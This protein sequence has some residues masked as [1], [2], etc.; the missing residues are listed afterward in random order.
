MC[1]FIGCKA[2]GYGSNRFIGRRGEDC[3]SIVRAN[4]YVFSHN[5]LSLTGTFNPQPFVD[6]RLFCLYNGELYNWQSLAEEIGVQVG[7]DGEILIPLYRKYGEKFLQKLDGE[8]AVVL[9]DLENQVAIFSSDSFRTKPIY[10]NADG[11][12]SYPSGLAKPSV[13]VPPNTTIVRDLKTGVEKSLLVH[14]FD[15]E[16][17]HK[18]TYD[19]W[20]AAF[21]AAILKRAKGKR[22]FLGLSSG[23]D[24]GAIHCALRKY[25]L[26]F[27]PFAIVGAE[28]VKMIQA[29]GV[30]PMVFTQA[31]FDWGRKFLNENMEDFEYQIYQTR[32]RIRNEESAFAMACIM[33]EARKHGARIYM[34]GQGADEIIADYGKWPTQSDFC[35]KFPEKLKPWRNFYGHCQEAYLAKEEHVGGTF[36]VE[37]RYAFLDLSVVQEF[38]WLHVDWKNRYYKA[39]IHEYMMRN[40]YPFRDGE[41]I[42]FSPQV[43]FSRVSVP[44]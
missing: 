33:R 23:Y 4:G 16:N 41:K 44:V 10:L 20:I 3:E 8:F 2:E 31:D 18:K 9:I 34:S 29:R 12:A 14:D 7:S 32:R 5:L 21:E 1:G 43:G 38:L 36:S 27:V 26:D 15:F 37:T 25:G 13:V 11:A 40:R 6:G 24:S 22:V 35:G 30:E 19:D 42:G 28:N 17:Q 39:P